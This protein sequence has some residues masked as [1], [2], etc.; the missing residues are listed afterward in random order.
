MKR[1]TKNEIPSTVSCQQASC[2]PLNESLVGGFSLQRFH[3][4]WGPH[5]AHFVKRW[6]CA[7]PACP[8]RRHAHAHARLPVDVRYSSQRPVLPQDTRLIAALDLVRRMPPARIEQTL[9]GAPPRTFPPHRG[10]PS[11]APRRRGRPPAQSWWI[12]CLT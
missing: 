6:R 8:G 9:E 7:P 2:P 3:T 12:S 10:D 4:L 5:F 1:G 11:T